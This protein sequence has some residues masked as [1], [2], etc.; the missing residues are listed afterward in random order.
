MIR[1]IAWCLALSCAAAHPAVASAESACE[2]AGATYVSVDDAGFTA[3]FAVMP[4]ARYYRGLAPYVRSAATHR[5]FWFQFD[6]GSAR[7]MNLMSI[8]DVTAPWRVKRLCARRG[9]LC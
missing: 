3:G 1:M 7:Y 8:M 4:P 2:A 9:V 5:T 6:S